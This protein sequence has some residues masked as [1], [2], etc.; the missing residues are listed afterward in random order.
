MTKH[1]SRSTCIK[2][3]TLIDTEIG[4]W[5][6]KQYLGVQVSSMIPSWI[7]VSN[8]IGQNMDRGIGIE[9]SMIKSKIINM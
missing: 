5:M 2:H 7:Q 1:F 9:Q 6:A 8:K 4:K 3:D